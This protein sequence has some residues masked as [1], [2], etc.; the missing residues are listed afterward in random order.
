MKASFVQTLA[1]PN[2]GT[3]DPSRL[4]Q[5]GP[6]PMRVV[7]RNTGGVVLFIAHDVADLGNISNIGATYQLPPGQADIF[8]LAPKQSIIAAAQGAGGQASIAV[9][10]A[11]PVDKNWMES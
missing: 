5:A 11:I 2:I 3:E 10:E 9:S 1:V 4:T 6:V 7:V 8:V